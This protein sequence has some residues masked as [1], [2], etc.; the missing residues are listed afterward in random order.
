MKNYIAEVFDRDTILHLRIPFSL[1]LFPIFCFAI[2]QASTLHW[3]NI[4]VVFISLHFFIYPGSNVYNSYMDNDK[5]SIGGLKNP[6]PT[7]VKL[8][9]ASIIMDM[10]GLML[11]FFVNVWLAGMMLV[12]IAVSK[13]YSWRGIRI[14]KYAVLSWLVVVI[15][16]GGFTFMLVNMCAENAFKKEWFNHKNI[17][18]TIIA[19]LLIGGFYPLTQIY[20][21]EEDSA[22]GDIT[23]SYRLGVI[24]TFLFTA[25]LFIVANGIAFYYFNSFYGINHFFLFNLC[26]LPVTAYFLYWFIVTLK[27]RSNADYDHSARMTVISSLSMIVCFVVIFF[28]NH[29]F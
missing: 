20:Q 21:H 13:A 15:F 16:Q 3:M 28:L 24:G 19:T 12:F 22:R 6:P 18:S 10:I 4:L 14:K 8:Y 25:L 9:Y 17:V 11:C 27:D 29:T 26:L 2:S 1:F 23:I 7:T 5:G